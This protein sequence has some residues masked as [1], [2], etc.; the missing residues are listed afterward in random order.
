MGRIE[1]EAT[2]MGQLVEDMLTLAR[3]DEQR[4]PKITPMDLNILAHESVMDLTVN[5][6]DREVRVVGLSD[7]SPS[8]APIHGDQGRIQQVVTNLVTNALRYTPAGSP[9]EL[10][11]GTDM[12]SSEHPESVL[13]VRD[14]GEGID[15]EDSEK[16]FQRFYRADNSRQR[17]TGG[18]GLGLAICAAIA[19]QHG[20]SVRHSRTEGGGATMTLRL[21]TTE[22]PE[23]D[24]TDEYDVDEDELQHLRAAA[25]DSYED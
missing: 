22:D 13:Q 18:T 15:A 10:A 23:L 19:A 8:S 1:S 3:L 12:Q 9:I 24:E 16:I 6:P 2:R 17:E 11:V 21:P 4:P 20:G 7:D 5:A 14:H 25:R